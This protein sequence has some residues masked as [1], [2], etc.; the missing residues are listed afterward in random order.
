MNG[1]VA[2]VNSLV[3]RGVRFSSAVV[4]LRRHFGAPAFGLIDAMIQIDLDGLAG[5]T[6]LD[7]LSSEAHALRRYRAESEARELPIRLIFPMLCCILPSFVLLTVVP[8]LAGTL[9]GLRT[10][11]G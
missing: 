7:R 9:I 11:L 5:P 6:T 1:V 2:E 10:H 8:M 3:R 4:E